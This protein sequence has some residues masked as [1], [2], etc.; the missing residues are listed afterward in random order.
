MLKPTML[1][2]CVRMPATFNFRKRWR[3]ATMTSRC[4]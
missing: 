1:R 2:T 4:V 3:S